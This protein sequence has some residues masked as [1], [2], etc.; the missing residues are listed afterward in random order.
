MRER[1]IFTLYV[2]YVKH[3]LD[4][5]VSYLWVDCPAPTAL[6]AGAGP[7]NPAPC[8]AG[9]AQGLVAGG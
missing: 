6:L 8:G 1:S 7:P 9:P 4:L 5:E 3:S 2:P